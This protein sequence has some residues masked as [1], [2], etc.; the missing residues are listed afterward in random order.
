MDT[1]YY[2]FSFIRV[3]IA[4]KRTRRNRCISLNRRRKTKKQA[5]LKENMQPPRANTSQRENYLG[6]EV[7]FIDSTLC[8]NK[9]VSAETGGSHFLKGKRGVKKGISKQTDCVKNDQEN[10]SFGRSF[11]FIHCMDIAN[12]LRNSRRDGV[13][14]LSRSRLFFYKYYRPF[15]RGDWTGS[16]FLGPSRK[17]SKSHSPGVCPGSASSALRLCSLPSEREAQ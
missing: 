8:S 9:M 6:N 7:F 16:C 11:R 13:R 5:E 12:A 4:S 15:A 1:K 3:C 2:L 14:K 17:T 10:V